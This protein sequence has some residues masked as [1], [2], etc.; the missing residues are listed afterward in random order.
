MHHKSPPPWNCVEQMRLP[1]ARRRWSATIQDCRKNQRG[2]SRRNREKSTSFVVSTL[3]STCDAELSAPRPNG[4][5]ASVRGSRPLETTEAGQ[6]SYFFQP[7]Y[8]LYQ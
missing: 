6:E 1:A 2:R 4:P 3:Q 5:D 8:L 7:A